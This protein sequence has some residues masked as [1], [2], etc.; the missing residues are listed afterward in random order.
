MPLWFLGLEV[1]FWG[2]SIGLEN[3]LGLRRVF[4]QI[5]FEAV[6]ITSQPYQ[7]TEIKVRILRIRWSQ[8]S[9]NRVSSY[10]ARKSLRRPL[11]ADSPPSTN[12][13]HEQVSHRS[14]LLPI[15]NTPQISQTGSLSSSSNQLNI[16]DPL[17]LDTQHL[18]LVTRKM[19]TRVL[20]GSQDSMR[21]CY[22]TPFF[23]E[24]SYSLHGPTSGCERS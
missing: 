22:L 24:K 8:R 21:A 23:T 19:M 10:Q 2:G 17:W 9:N 4:G 18:R 7:L 5:L 20:G 15:L 12:I 14:R 11:K 6:H 16:T 3:R 1:Y 13:S